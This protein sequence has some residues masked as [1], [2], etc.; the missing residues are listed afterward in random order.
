M[1][2]FLDTEFIEPGIHPIPTIELISIGLVC[3]DD[4]EY[5]A[6]A[7][8]FDRTGASDWVKDNVFLYLPEAGDPLWKKRE[9]IK[10]DILDFIGDDPNPRFYG[11]YADYDWVVFCWLFGRMIDLPRAFPKYCLDL[12]QML[13][14]IGNPKVPFQSENEHNAL[15]D[16]K[17]NKKVFDFVIEEEMK[18]NA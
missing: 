8:G 14:E 11:Y 12:K 5:Y 6:F 15:S 13:Y 17:W 16:A 10:Q 9:V 2:Y 1:R 3:E 4:R 7:Q 18:Q